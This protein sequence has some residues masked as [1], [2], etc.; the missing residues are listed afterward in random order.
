M[1]KIFKVILSL[2]A[3]FFTVSV[4]WIIIILAQFPIDRIKHVENAWQVE[5]SNNVNNDLEGGSQVS[6]KD[7][8]AYYI[9]SASKPFYQKW[10]NS[11][12]KNNE[13]AKIPE[14]SSVFEIIKNT[15]LKP[16]LKNDCEKVYCYQ[17]RL[18]FEEIPSIF[19]RGLIGVEDHRFINHI[20]IDFKSLLRAII[21]D[22]RKMEF[23]QGGS[24]LTQQLVKNI[25]LTNEKKFSRKIKE[26]IISIYIESK[27]D[28]EQI[29]E[30][31]FNEFLWGS[32]QGMRIKGI[33]SASV[34][35][36]SKRPHEIKP[37][38]AAILV[39]MLNGPYLFNPL[40]NL[41]RLKKRTEIVYKKLV[42]LDLFPKG[43][44]SEWKDR[45][46]KE[47]VKSLEEKNKNKPYVAIWKSQ[48][49]TKNLL[50]S[51]ESFVFNKAASETELFLKGYLK[52]KDMAVKA[53]VSQP[54]KNINK[55]T[56]Q[57][58]SKYERNEDL[59]I[60][61]EKHSVGSILKP[62][63]YKIFKNNGKKFTDLV[64]TESIT[65]NLKSGKWEPRESHKNL[66]SEV[67][68]AEAL[69]HSYNRPVIR[70][71]NDIG[72]DKI[73][74]ELLTYIPNLK[75]PLAEY[76]AQLL[77]A[78]ELS[79]KEIYD[80]YEKFIH[81]ECQNLNYLDGPENSLLALLS[82]PKQTTLHRVIGKE[83]GEHR[84]FGKTGTS[85]KGQDNLFVFFD[86]NLLGAIWTGLEG[87]R[88]GDD[89]HLAGATTSFRIYQRFVRDRGKRVSELN[90]EG[91]ES[92]PF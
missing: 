13:I 54:L 83:M 62:I 88:S 68:L 55:Q 32:M 77:G 59:A 78:I 87:E 7:L 75:T 15:E 92:L 71:A 51:Y 38:E 31:Y 50:S 25:Y 2:F 61:K 35:Y 74:K 65:L 81:L 70:L 42:K 10:I 53:Y 4:I 20:G 22:I 90:C 34:F 9:F 63:L 69:H 11:K 72:F 85:N 73:E 27:F 67:T 21:V 41:E 91:S 60:N 82:D 29:L 6:K 23:A 26:M 57:F 79:L 16:L 86:G 52:G 49:Q 1:K 5:Q 12:L 76:P 39:S 14:D 8:E 64:S 58:Y 40:R 37:Y 33:F 66:P 24:T 45:K 89:L 30:A 43:K 17:H 36:F 46:W 18:P 56:Y 48:K 44:H 28:K 80:V 47:W 84:F 19:W 3:L